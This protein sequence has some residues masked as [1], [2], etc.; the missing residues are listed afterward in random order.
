MKSKKMKYLVPLS[1]D[2]ADQSWAIITCQKTKTDNKWFNCPNLPCCYAQTD[3]EK[4]TKANAFIV[5]KRLG[6]I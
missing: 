1:K 4:D 6:W 3:V 5:K 2:I